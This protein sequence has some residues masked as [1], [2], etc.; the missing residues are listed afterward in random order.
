MLTLLLPGWLY[1][2][3]RTTG[4]RRRSRGPFG[5]VILL[6]RAPPPVWCVCRELGGNACVAVLRVV[7]DSKHLPTSARSRRPREPRAAAP[8]QR[9]AHHERRRQGVRRLRAR[10]AGAP[11]PPPVVAAGRRGSDARPRYGDWSARSTAP[12]PRVYSSVGARRC[13][14]W[15]R[16]K[17]CD[18]SKVTYNS[19]AGCPYVDFPAVGAAPQTVGRSAHAC[20]MVAHAF[21]Q[22]LRE[23]RVECRRARPSV[24]PRARSA[25]SSSS[26]VGAAASAHRGRRRAT[27]TLVSSAS[28]SGA[29][30]HH[31]DSRLP[32]LQLGVGERNGLEH[33]PGSSLTGYP[34]TSDPSA[35]A[36]RYSYCRSWSST[37]YWR[38]RSSRSPRRTPRPPRRR[39]RS[40]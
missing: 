17:C 5:E 12:P 28:E 31:G 25:S 35:A 4:R 26:E 38:A 23:A 37:A 1:L 34:G 30:N 20:A 11:R 29:S 39:N 14:K 3:G 40:A 21:R 19:L 16:A 27:P 9:R 22:R 2:G 7:T 24:A 6:C 18:S 32:H 33:R 15:R 8:V 10:R 13:T 36:G